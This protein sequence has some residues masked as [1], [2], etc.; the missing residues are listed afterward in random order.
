ML[1]QRRRRIETKKIPP[2]L[3]SRTALHTPIGISP[4]RDMGVNV[5][6]RGAEVRLMGGSGVV[7]GVFGE[8]SKTRDCLFLD[9]ETR[10]H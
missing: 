7:F 6:G 2:L 3:V 4:P 8:F 5:S 10:E 1:H 9:G